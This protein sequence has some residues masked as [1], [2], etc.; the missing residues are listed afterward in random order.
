MIAINKC[1][2]F[3]EDCNICG[4]YI[5]DKC[6]S[7]YVIDD[8]SKCINYFYDFTAKCKYCKEF[9]EPNGKCLKTG[10]CKIYHQYYYPNHICEHYIKR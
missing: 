5:D 4:A 1:P 10:F 8:M 2:V 9:I 3:C 6:T 7:K